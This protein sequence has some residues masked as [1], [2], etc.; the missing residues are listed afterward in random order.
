M[1]TEPRLRSRLADRASELIASRQ[2]FVRATVV[3]AQSP[4][5][6]RPGDSAII[7]SDGTIEGFVGG[8]CAKESVRAA[9]FTT[10]RDG[11]ALLLRVLPDDSAVFPETPGAQLTINPCLSGGALE[12]FL[13]PQLPPAVVEVF[14]D[15]PVADAVAA[16][17]ETVGFAVGRSLPGR[18]VEGAVAVIVST[19]GDDEPECIRAALDAGVGFIGLVASRVRGESVLDAMDLTPAERARVHTPV[20]VDIGAKTAAEIGLSIVAGIVAAVRVDGVVAGD[21]EPVAS[22]ATALDPICGMTVVVLP[23]TAHLRADGVDYWFCSQGCR[24]H[25][26]AQVGQA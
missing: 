8:H 9:A 19:H 24:D 7:L 23:T 2:P 1:T 14:G 4:T 16:L 3:R 21:A 11:E 10:L 25:Y 12:I 15:T 13:E 18:A 20:G 5:S 17:A 22:P 6:A 26:A